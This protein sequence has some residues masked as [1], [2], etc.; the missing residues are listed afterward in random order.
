MTCSTPA[1]PSL[2]RIET[3]VVTRSN[4]CRDHVS[5]ELLAPGL[6]ESHPGQFLQIHCRSAHPRRD[7]ELSWPGGGFPS[8]RT[9]DDWYEREPFL[10]R[11]FSIADRWCDERSHTHV[12][13]I[14]RNV[15]PGTAWLEQLAVGAT[16]NVIGPLGHGFDVPRD[17]GR[18]MLLGG[19]V[20][21]PPLLYLARRL[22]EHGHQDVTAVFGA[23]TRDL[24]PLRLSAPPAG[25][26]QPTRC[27]ELPGQAPFAAAI[28]T[29][30]GSL[31]MRGVVTDALRRLCASRFDPAVQGA[32]VFA[33]GPE[34][35]L[36]AVA[37][38]TRQLGLRCQLSIER[39]M[40]CGLGTCLSCIVRVRDD[41]KPAGWQWALACTDGPVFDRDKLC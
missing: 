37:A 32:M 36:S 2:A 11:P 35:M 1:K 30:D 34:P 15:G 22:H 9:T 8:L 40:G 26:G 28:T 23:T 24:L 41:R 3:R 4:I 18:L 10:R 16:V 19:G 17:S 27:V 25:N 39:N 21:I 12:V 31:G 6:P 13:I 14:S 38:L 5:I 20:G 29:D 33:C 7:G